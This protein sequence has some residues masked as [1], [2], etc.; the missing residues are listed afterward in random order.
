[1]ANDI[2]KARQEAARLR[3]SYLQ[4]PGESPDVDYKAAC[5]FKSGD[6]FSLDL[7]RHILGMANAGGGYIVI[8]Y[9]EDA[10]GNPQPDASLNDAIA[11]AYD[12]SNLAS[13]VERHVRG[14]D[15]VD[16]T[17]YKEHFSGRTFPMISVGPFER[18]PFFCKSKKKNSKGEIVLKEGAL[19]FRNA[20]ARTVE[21]AGPAEWEKLVDICVERRQNETVQRVTDSLERAGFQISRPLAQRQKR[22][23]KE[24]RNLA[25]DK[26]DTRIKEIEKFALDAR[27]EA[28]QSFKTHGLTH[29]HIEVTHGPLRNHRWTQQQLL[30]AAEKSSLHR[31]GWPMGVVLHNE[32]RPKPVTRGIVANIF[33]DFISTH[34]DYW[35]LSTK[36]DFYLAR[37]FQE[38]T[39]SDTKADPGKV[40]FFDTQIWRIAEAFEHASSLYKNLGLKP[41]EPFWI[42]IRYK[43]LKGRVLASSTP[44][45]ELSYE[46]TTAEDE[47]AWEGKVTQDMVNFGLKEYVGAVVDGLFAMF[48]FFKLSPQVVDELVRGYLASRI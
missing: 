5:S 19:Y 7:V 26:V 4:Y 21:L 33:S 12:A 11:A 24:R 39:R 47:V 8:G 31:T 16:L 35:E 15:K 13:F 2:S 27:K 36:G 28:E 43:G 3:Q 20:S 40:L 23:T 18:R 42:R 10:S 14:E 32:S 9:K 48:D 29:G 30:E 38:D 1:M 46:R 44:A 17:I 45:R 34:V 25:K 22:Q 41:G 37:N 6:D